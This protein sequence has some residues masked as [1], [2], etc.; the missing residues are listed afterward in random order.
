MICA[1]AY[2]A[3]KW[4]DNI[5]VLVLATV[6]IGVA[7]GLAGSVFE[8]FTATTPMLPDRMLSGML[9]GVAAYSAIATVIGVG[10][11]LLRK[12]KS[13]EKNAT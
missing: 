3:A 7:G 10:A 11:Y 13:E 1:A 6:L 5:P 2:L 4:A 12:W 9:I 8:I